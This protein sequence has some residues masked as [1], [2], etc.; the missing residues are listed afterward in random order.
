MARL[1]T[2][3]DIVF[4]KAQD[5]K[6]RLP[7]YFVYLAKGIMD[8]QIARLYGEYPEAIHFSKSTMNR[9]QHEL[10]RIGRINEFDALG[11]AIKKTLAELHAE[12]HQQQENVPYKPPEHTAAEFYQNCGAYDAVPER[13]QD[14]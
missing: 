2:P 8:H 14:A 13:G 7:K 1:F 6:N 12:G 9:F 10:V 11:P 4:N 3:G 5:P